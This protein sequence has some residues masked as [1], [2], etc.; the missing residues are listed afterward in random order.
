MGASD[1]TGN[2][3]CW[4]GAPRRSAANTTRQRWEALN[5]KEGKQSRYRSRDGSAPRGP[6]GGSVL[7]L[8]TQTETSRTLRGKK[9][10][11]FG[12]SAL[13]GTAVLATAFVTMV[14]ASAAPG[15]RYHRGYSV[16]GRW[17]CYGWSNG[18]FHCTQRWHRSGGSLISNNP[19]WVPNAGGAS[20]TH[21]SAPA[22]A[23]GKGNTAPSGH[24][25]AINSAGEPCRSTQYFNGTPSQWQVPPSCYAGVYWV[26]PAHYVYRSG[27]GWCNWWPEVMNPSRPNLLWGN[28]PRGYTP[29]PGATVVFAP[30][31]QGAGGAGH[32]GRVVAVY[33]GGNWF[34]ISERNFTW[35]G[36]G[37]ARVEYRYV[38]TGP[39]VS[40]I[41]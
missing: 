22:H 19:T 1:M 41:Y 10:L 38:H 4:N 18:S 35:R 24:V 20:S 33:P 27:F 17:L 15:L 37:F 40:F 9:A 36:A 21:T 23:A 30:G 6:K 28:Y 8:E 29:R 13:L 31:V 2:A 7:T 39:G 32:Y 11:A 26:N 5:L 3:G 34:L 16:Q 14:T 25:Q 12:A